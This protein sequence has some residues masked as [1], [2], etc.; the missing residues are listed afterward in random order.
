V[1][2]GRRISNN[3]ISYVQTS[4]VVLAFLVALTSI[5][6]VVHMNLTQDC[7]SVL[8]VCRHLFQAMKPIRP[9]TSLFQVLLPLTCK[10]VHLHGPR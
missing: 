2:P 5:H 9:T 1:D 4:F 3:P 10:C 7:L 8:H 6:V